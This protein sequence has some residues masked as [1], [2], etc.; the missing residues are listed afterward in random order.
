MLAIVDNIIPWIGIGFFAVMAWFANNVNQ[1]S[2]GRKQA[3]DKAV[4]DAAEREEKGREAVYDLRD[5]NRDDLVQRL[6]DNDGEW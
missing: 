2:K 3:D 6:R 1:R 4:L 5:A